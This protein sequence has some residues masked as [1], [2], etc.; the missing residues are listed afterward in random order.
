[1][2]VL[3]DTHV[4]LWLQTQPERVRDDVRA[5]LADERA[6]LLLSAVSSWEIAIKHARG[7]LPLPEPPHTYVPSRMRSDAVDGLPVTHAHALRVA[8]LPPH[9]GDPF[10]RL[11]V[12]QAQVEKLT[13]VTV[14]PQIERYDVPVIRA[15]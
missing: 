11:L 9:H 1:V 6:E 10:D 8:S 15:D 2:K 14:D 5:Q 7:K 13:I 3:L 4:W 12:A